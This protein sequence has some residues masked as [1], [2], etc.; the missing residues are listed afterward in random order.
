MCIPFCAFRR[1][2][3][4]TESR[5]PRITLLKLSANSQAHVKCTLNTPIY[6]RRRAPTPLGSA[7]D[8]AFVGHLPCTQTK[9]INLCLLRSTPRGLFSSETTQIIDLN[10]TPL[11]QNTISTTPPCFFSHT[12]SVGDSIV[13]KKNGRFHL[14]SP[15]NRENPFYVHGQIILCNKGCCLAQFSRRKW[16]CPLT[17]SS[18][19]KTGVCC[20]PSFLIGCL[21][22]SKR[23]GEVPV[24]TI[25]YFTSVLDLRF[26]VSN[27]KVLDFPL[28]RKEL[29]R[30]NGDTPFQLSFKNDFIP[31]SVSLFVFFSSSFIR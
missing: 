3:K 26:N 5:S 14:F 22:S 18:P 17:W 1:K 24:S 19:G 13:L 4:D 15:K 21:I 11:R 16:H 25:I 20:L 29:W 27:P 31:S 2:S 10:G 28:N 9:I 30:H 6:Y 8:C 7:N 12:S 23:P